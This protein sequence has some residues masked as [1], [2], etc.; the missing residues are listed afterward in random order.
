MGYTDL[1]TWNQS[2][3]FVYSK[4]QPFQA[5]DSGRVFHSTGGPGWNVV[6]QTAGQFF[7]NYNTGT[8]DG[9]QNLLY[10]D[11]PLAAAGATGGIGNF[12]GDSPSITPIY[13]A[14]CE[15]NSLTSG[16]GSSANKDYPSQLSAILGPYWTVRNRGV[17]GRTTTQMAAAAA[18]RDAFYD[19]VNYQRNIL[20]AWEIINEIGANSL[21]A[22]TAF[23][24]FKQY[25]QDAKEA[26]WYVVAASVT[27]ATN[28]DS[29]LA[30]RITAANELMSEDPASYC[31]LL[32]KLHLDNRLSAVNSTFFSD[33]V[34]YNDVGYGA[35]AN[36]FAGALLTAFSFDATPPAPSVGAIRLITL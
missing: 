19:P 35:A 4:S 22:L 28:G 36:D 18:G 14:V 7:E 27:A 29:T 5:S 23:N 11:P 17:S 24:N 6:T 31:D 21:P 2:A 13:Q 32:V 8:P 25:C 20:I 33:G 3:G 1:Q 12:E 10:F 16:Y 15:G 26:G 34:H 9:I 30:G